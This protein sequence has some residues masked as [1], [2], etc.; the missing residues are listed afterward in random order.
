MGMPLVKVVLAP[1]LRRFAKV[2]GNVYVSGNTVE[3]VITALNLNWQGIRRKILDEEGNVLPTLE[4]LVNE[5]GIDILFGLKTPVG[6]DDEIW[7]IPAPYKPPR[8]VE[9]KAWGKATRGP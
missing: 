5:K 4:I 1:C 9:E 7:I 2:T 6:G 8:V 3:A